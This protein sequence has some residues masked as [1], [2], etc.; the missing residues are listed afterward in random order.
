MKAFGM[1]KIKTR[2]IT[3]IRYFSF[4]QN[5]RKFSCS[6]NNQKKGKK[7]L[8]DINNGSFVFYSYSEYQID[9]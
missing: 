4:V 2:S 5:I 9:S 1:L 7:G 6:N 3:N 8:N